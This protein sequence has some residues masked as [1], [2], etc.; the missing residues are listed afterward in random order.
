MSEESALL[1][2]AQFI[3]FHFKNRHVTHTVHDHA[4]DVLAETL[5]TWEAGEQL[6][7]QQHQDKVQVHKPPKKAMMRFASKAANGDLQAYMRKHLIR[8]D[9]NRYLC[10]QTVLCPARH[11]HADIIFLSSTPLSSVL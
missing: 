2:L 9:C 4:Q 5:Q 1:L 3:K 8:E 11:A 10:Q 6:R 7:T